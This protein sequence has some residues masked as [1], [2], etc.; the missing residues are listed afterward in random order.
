V[1]CEAGGGGAGTGIV[2]DREQGS[3]PRLFGV[4]VSE[5]A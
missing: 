4:S 5:F 2:G 3:C 1:V